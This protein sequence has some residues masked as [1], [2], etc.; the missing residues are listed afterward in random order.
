[1][2][3]LAR[4]S[5]LHESVKAVEQGPV[6]IEDSSA[7]RVPVAP[8]EMERHNAAQQL[9]VL[10][11]QPFSPYWLHAET[12]RSEPND[13]PRYT[14]RYQP[15]RGAQATGAS[16]LEH[17]PIHQGVMPPQLWNAFTRS[18]TKR[19]ARA[20]RAP[21][22]RVEIDWDNLHL[23]EKKTGG[24]GEEDAAPESD[25]EDRGEYEDEDEDDYAQNYFDN[26]ED[27]DEGGGDDGDEAAFD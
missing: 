18:E 2:A 17:V 15:E 8:S 9:A 3:A 11:M 24:E 5:A 25:E 21:T 20:R 22:G 6:V 26:G 14:D 16:F 7:P 19:E 10:R 4:G 13:M 27:D 12:R 1:M 23:E